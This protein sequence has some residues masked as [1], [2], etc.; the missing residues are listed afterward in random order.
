MLAL[1][2]GVYEA[3][4]HIGLGVSLLLYNKWLLSK[5]SNKCPKKKLFFLLFFDT[6]WTNLWEYVFHISSV[7]VPVSCQEYVFHKLVLLY[8]RDLV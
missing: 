7:D 4:R 8:S 6:T 5:N 3:R 1:K 2:A